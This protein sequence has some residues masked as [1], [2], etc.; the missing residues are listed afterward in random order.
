MVAE[1]L[2]GTG[3][4]LRLE[5]VVLGTPE[6]VSPGVS[7]E[8]GWWVQGRIPPLRRRHRTDH[9]KGPPLRREDRNLGFG[10]RDACPGLDSVR[11]LW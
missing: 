3:L 1:S 6:E 5:E 11:I 8:V 9:S 7:A 4:C 10:S 2:H